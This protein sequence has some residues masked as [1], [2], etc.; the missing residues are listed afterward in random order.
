M[1]YGGDIVSEAK[2]PD[3]KM[4]FE[5]YKFLRDETIMYTKINNDLLNFAITSTITLLSVS[6][7]YSEVSIFLP[8]LAYFIIIPIQLRIKHYRNAIMRISAYMIVFLE[9]RIPEINWETALATKK[10]DY[11]KVRTNRI[12]GLFHWL[13]YSELTMLGIACT[14]V[15]YF[16]YSFPQSLSINNVKIWAIGILP[17]VLCIYIHLSTTVAN[18]SYELKEENIEFW[19]KSKVHSKIFEN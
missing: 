3:K 6:L 14:I 1:N 5:E 11:D 18:K 7:L 2:Q 12:F 10:P 9:P 8:L 17:L 19:K 16:Y 4:I 15:F 13:R